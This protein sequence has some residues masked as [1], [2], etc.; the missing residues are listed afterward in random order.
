MK[1]SRAPSQLAS[2][3]TTVVKR[4][5]VSR[6]PRT[7]SSRASGG[8]ART[9]FPERL[10]MKHKYVGGFTIAAAAGGALA[11]NQ[12]LA[13]GL[14]DPDVTSTGHQPMLY[15]QMK[16]I[17]DH[18]TVKSSKI[19]ITFGQDTQ[20]IGSV[21][22]I[23]LND[24]SSVTPTAFYD[25]G[26]QR[27]GTLTFLPKLGAATPKTLRLS[28]DSKKMFGS[29]GTTNPNLQGSSGADPTE[30]AVYTIFGQAVD[31]STAFSVSGTVELEYTVEWFELKDLAAS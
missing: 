21:I 27:N 18:W 24:D 4:Q 11:T 13:N 23:F 14:F 31:I 30:T 17:Y 3:T 8:K 29:D 12:F 15:D 25:C 19:K 26:E 22:G 2:Q 5:N 10:V 1:R 9:G 16:A 7:L 6:I 20:L 28:F